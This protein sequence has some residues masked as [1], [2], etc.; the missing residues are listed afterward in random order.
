MSIER[1]KPIL[2]D[3]L[4]WLQDLNWPGANIIMHYLKHY[5]SQLLVD[6]YEEATLSAV[7]T[8][9]EPWLDYLSYFTYC[10]KFDL[11]NFKNQELLQILRDHEEFW[12][13]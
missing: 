12:I 6:S 3:L 13:T 7:N 8:K 1:T 2:H 4:V 10:G 11:Y 9:D 5:P